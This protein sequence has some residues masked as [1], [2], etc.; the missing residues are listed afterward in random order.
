MFTAAVVGPLM[1]LLAAFAWDGTAKLRAGREAFNIAEEAARAGA[2]YVDRCTAY[3]MC[4]PCLPRLSRAGAV[5]PGAVVQRV[6]GAGSGAA[7]RS[8]PAGA[9][10]W[11]CYGRS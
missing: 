6:V 8:K 10:C 4:S 1:L 5:R 7:C 9:R 3:A 2:G 11:W